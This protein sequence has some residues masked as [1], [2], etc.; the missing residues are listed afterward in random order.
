MSPICQQ[1]DPAAGLCL[2]RHT[3]R[4]WPNYCSKLTAMLACVH[5]IKIWQHQLLCKIWKGGG[6]FSILNVLT[7]TSGTAS[8]AASPSNL[9]GSETCWSLSGSS[10]ASTVLLRRQQQC[11]GELSCTTAQQL[12]QLTQQLAVTVRSPSWVTAASLPCFWL[13]RPP[14]HQ[15]F[16]RQRSHQHSCTLKQC[17][18]GCSK[19]NNDS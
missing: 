2:S 18:S 3:G 15:P 14:T 10:L 9:H 19:R 8:L 16:N 4:K 13:T 17:T 1:Q 6:G 7:E 11:L 12:T 5:V